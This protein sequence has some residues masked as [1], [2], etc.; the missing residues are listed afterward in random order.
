ME[1]NETAQEYYDLSGKFL[2]AALSNLESELHEPALANAIHSLELE[3]KALL[4]L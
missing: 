2:K 1:Q 3:I 4:F